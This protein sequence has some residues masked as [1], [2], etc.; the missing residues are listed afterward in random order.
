[1][2]HLICL[3]GRETIAL[4][5]TKMNNWSIHINGIPAHWAAVNIVVVSGSLHL[6]LPSLWYTAAVAVHTAAHTTSTHPQVFSEGAF[7]S[8]R[9]SAECLELKEVQWFSRWLLT[10]SHLQSSVTCVSN[11][12]EREVHRC[13]HCSPPP[14]GLHSTQ[15]SLS[16]CRFLLQVIPLLKLEGKF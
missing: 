7:H 12:L 14:R 8:G 6:L 16:V 1:M 9:S 10:A 15:S 11:W 3:L 4:W 5:E 2:D 13:C